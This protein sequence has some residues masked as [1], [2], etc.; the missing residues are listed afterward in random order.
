MRKKTFV[1]VVLLLA[2]ICAAAAAW[3]S[4]MFV[5]TA[6][7][8]RGAIFLGYGPTPQ[9]ATE[10]AV[11]NCTQHSFLPPSC[12][13][14]NVRMECPPPPPCP[15]PG[16]SKVPPKYRGSAA[17]YGGTPGLTPQA[18]RSGYNFPARAESRGSIDSTARKLDASRSVP[19]SPS[20]EEDSQRPNSDKAY[21]WGRTSQ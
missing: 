15:P 19:R 6:K 17:V 16:I 2:L 1:V 21:R 3:A 20:V 12:R 5:A 10:A 13:V 14:I 18:A 8:F 4:P 9:H 7:N 11:S